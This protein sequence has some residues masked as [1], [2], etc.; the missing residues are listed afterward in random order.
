M[1]EENYV[2]TMISANLKIKIKANAIGNINLTLWNLEN[3]IVEN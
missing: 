1:E 3:D 2:K